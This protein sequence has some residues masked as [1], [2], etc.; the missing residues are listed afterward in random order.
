MIDKRTS[1]DAAAIDR[2]LA[3][4]E[5]GAIIPYWETEQEYFTGSSARGVFK[6]N[7]ENFINRLA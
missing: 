6:T 1:E 7:V 5:T 3:M 4:I 2:V